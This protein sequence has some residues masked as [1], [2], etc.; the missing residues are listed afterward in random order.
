MTSRS[1]IV[2][3]GGPAGLS[4]GLGLLRLKIPTTIFDQRVKWSGRVCGSFLNSE[5]VQH[6]KWLNVWTEVMSRNPSPVRI[7]TLSHDHEIVSHIPMKQKQ[8]EAIAFPRKDLEEVLRIAFETKGGIFKEGARVI[9]TDPVTTN[10]GQPHLAPIVIFAD[11]RFSEAG[12][13]MQTTESNTAGWYGWNAAFRNTNMNAGDMSLNL[14]P[15]G[16][17][18]VLTFADGSTNVCGLTYRSTNNRQSWDECF[19]YAKRHNALLEKTL[20]NAEQISTWQGVGPLPFCRAMRISE[21][22]FLAGDAAA[23]GDP[24]MGEG[25]GRAL[26]A[27]PMLFKA[28][29]KQ[30]PLGAYKQMWNTSYLRRLNMSHWLRKTLTKPAL[31]PML[32]NTLFRLPWFT[33]YATRRFHVGYNA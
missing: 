21:K 23:V 15:G 6:L 3:G 22:F 11:G 8:D 19:L 9:N 10:D 7:T 30:D 32:A 5:S 2:I 31:T 26:G 33:K 24:F 17:V 16:Y 18:G 28:L 14:I 25:I 29:Q 27:G 4:A 20:R 12:T 13:K 1:A